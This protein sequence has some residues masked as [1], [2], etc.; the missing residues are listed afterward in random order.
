MNH[1]LDPVALVV[2]MLGVLFSPAMAQILGPYLFIFIAASVGAF[3]ALGQREPTDRLGGL[4]FW[5]RSVAAA[6]LLTVPLALVLNR[7]VVHSDSINWMLG[8]VAFGLG[9]IGDKWGAIR[10]WVGQKIADLT[11]KKI[12]GN[13]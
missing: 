5:L 13:Q 3:I 6:L 10:A 8:P 11:G 1:P 7:V 4:A 12:G 9:M 2:A